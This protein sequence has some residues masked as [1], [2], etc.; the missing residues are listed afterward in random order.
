[1]ISGRYLF[2]S[3]N[4]FEESKESAS[5][6]TSPICCF[7]HPFLRLMNDVVA[8]KDACVHTQRWPAHVR[9][10]SA[11][12]CVQFGVLKEGPEGAGD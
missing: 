11:C 5:R 3:P 2:I 1:M 10:H 12:V 8:R 9:R 4:I 7:S 6:A